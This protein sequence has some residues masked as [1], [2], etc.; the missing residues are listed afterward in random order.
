MATAPSPSQSPVHGAL[1][2]ALGTGEVGGGV[3]LGDR[4]GVAGGVALGGAGD[5]LAVR[6][7]GGSVAPGV[8]DAPTVITFPLYGP[9][10]AARASGEIAK[11][12]GMGADAP[13]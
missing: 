11:L 3:G 5:G 2:V 9:T 8:K 12:A 4:V 10:G 6:V 7:A 13:R 1:A